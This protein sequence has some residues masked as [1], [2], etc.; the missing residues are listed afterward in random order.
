MRT[1]I[2][3]ILTFLSIFTI[4]RADREIAITAKPEGQPYAN[5]LA[6]EVLFHYTLLGFA[7]YG[8]A[9]KEAV[10]LWQVNKAL[11]ETPTQEQLSA[12]RLAWK[13][14]RKAYERAEVFRFQSSPIEA[15]GLGTA[16]NT[17]PIKESLI[18]KDSPEATPG[19]IDDPET[20][21]KINR[22]LLVKLARQDKFA[23]VLTG[24]HVIEYLLWGKDSSLEGPGVRAITDFTEAPFASRRL[25]YLKTVSDLLV[26]HLGRLRTDW[27]DENYD[28]FAGSLLMEEQSAVIQ[29]VF[30]GLRHL[31][32][33][34]LLA[35]RLRQPL[36]QGDPAL[37]HSPY[38]DTTLQD[39]QAVLEGL[40][41]IYTGRYT[42]LRSE[43]MEGKGLQTLVKSVDEKLASEMEVAITKA[44]ASLATIQSPFDRLI[45]EKEKAPDYAQLQTFIANL[46]ALADHLDKVMEAL[47][48]TH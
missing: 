39:V 32:R 7:L 43:A 45:V 10:T 13:D 44:S 6:Y 38:A 42:P 46:E 27:E 3:I 29:R 41:A 5:E 30:R 23:G 25:E 1:T 2:L 35:K 9:F 12:A 20:Y 4:C 48:I 15:K 8:D 40:L 33:D 47:K 17:S 34:E 26:F 21:P 28:N 37:E 24:W 18:E 22:Q 36:A 31:L 14:A 16:L 19:I 11:A